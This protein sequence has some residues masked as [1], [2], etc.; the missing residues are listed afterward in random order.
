MKD[1]TN[2]QIG[3]ENVAVLEK[4]LSEDFKHSLLIVSL[5]ANT[6]ILVAW[7]TLQVTS[8]Y[9]YEIATFLFFR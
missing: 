2:N 7:V 5:L 3:I 6:F 1:N 9:D 4:Q 8:Q